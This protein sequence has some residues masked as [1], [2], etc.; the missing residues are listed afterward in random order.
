MVYGP[1]SKFDIKKI[2]DNPQA[3]NPSTSSASFSG[4]VP[5]IPTAEA[6]ILADAAEA[7][8]L[9]LPSEGDN[10]KKRRLSSTGKSR[11]RTVD[12]AWDDEMLAL[13]KEMDDLVEV[14]PEFPEKPKGVDVGKVDRMLQKKFKEAKDSHNLDHKS[15]VESLQKKHDALRAAMKAAN[16]YLGKGPPKKTKQQPFFEKFVELGEAWPEAQQKFPAAYQRHLDDAAFAKAIDNEEFE[17]AAQ[18]CAQTACNLVHPVSA[19]EASK[20]CVSL[21]EK[22]ISCVMDKYDS[23]AVD[24][25]SSAN[26]PGNYASIRTSLST[27]L[28]QVLLVGAFSSVDD[29]CK[30]IQAL[31]LH[32]AD[33]DGT[34]NDSL[35]TLASCV[36]EPVYR[37][38]AASDFGRQAT[39]LAN[40]HNMQLQTTQSLLKFQVELK[41]YFLGLLAG[42]ALHDMLESGDS[43]DCESVL[44][45]MPEIE[46]HCAKMSGLKMDYTHDLSK[47]CASAFMDMF[48]ALQQKLLEVLKPHAL[49]MMELFTDDTT[50]LDMLDV[51]LVA[52]CGPQVSLFQVFI[53]S[54]PICGLY[55]H[56]RTQDE[57]SIRALCLRSQQRC[58]LEDVIYPAVPQDFI[59]SSN[60]HGR[61]VPWPD[62]AWFQCL[63]KSSG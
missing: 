25:Y 59:L 31:C 37:A 42:G 26:E 15:L 52:I 20:R 8:A 33:L 1:G 44:E 3:T 12:E 34:L 58:A 43:D 50:A 27:L 56:I 30:T 9:G 63:V 21:A 48:F 2:P 53:A 4:P 39:A 62:Q 57:A 11:K 51:H 5:A 54:Q 14:L 49:H 60:A 17:K 55:T 24:P 18:S 41:D 36:E 6:D 45:L 32:L 23:S 47:A 19:D 61:L 35:A 7:A 16:D 29:P 40:K 38:F 13:Q 46:K 10:A 22:A 28:E